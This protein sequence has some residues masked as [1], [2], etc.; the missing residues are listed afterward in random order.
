M[1]WTNEIVKKQCFFL[2]YGPIP[3]ALRTALTCV[4]AVIGIFQP[5]LKVTQKLECILVAAIS[6]KWQAYV[7]AGYVCLPALVNMH[8]GLEGGGWIGTKKG[9]GL[10]AVVH[11]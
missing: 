3:K 6:S 5:T 9:A 2:I 1:G 8:R 10:V 11:M 7:P 4:P